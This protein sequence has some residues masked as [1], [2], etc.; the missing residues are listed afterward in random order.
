VR[1]PASSAVTTA[2]RVQT[3][4]I[5]L[6]ARKGFAAAGIRELASEAGLTPA[7]LYHYM[8]TKEDLLVEIMRSTIVPLHEAA[9]DL[10]ATLP[11]AE[12]QLAALVEL[13]VWV[14][15]TRP[16]ATLVTDTEVR[17][18]AGER[19]KD[20][21][22]LRDRYQTLWREVLERGV[23]QGRFDV[24][25][26]ALATIGLLE[27]CTGVAHW[28]RPDGPRPLLEVCAAHA[29]W[30]LRLVDARRGGRPVRR[31]QLRLPAPEEWAPSP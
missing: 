21:L 2:P 15:G 24:P 12:R 11:E 18:L 26:P 13:H 16:L 27:L 14:H 31:A 5:E 17:A 8:G 3:A 10:L 4:A 30:A 23:A 1:T 20:V 6:F 28:Y 19:R 9:D 25:D 7:A 22:A 29:D